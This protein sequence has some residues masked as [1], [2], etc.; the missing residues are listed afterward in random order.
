MG[1]KRRATEV[2]EAK[3]DM[4]PI[5]DIVFNLLIFFLFYELSLVP[6]YFLINQWGG[7]NRKYASTKFFLYSL[8]GSLGMLLATCEDLILL[9][10]DRAVVV[11]LLRINAARIDGATSVK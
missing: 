4:T 11:E 7:P 9:G 6:M 3:A 8:G 2:E 10:A 1:I 5:I